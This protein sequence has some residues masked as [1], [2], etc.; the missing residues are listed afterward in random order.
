MKI[1]IVGLGSIGQRHARNLR[2]I[3][4][5]S[6]EL[7]AW[8]VRALT[9]VITPAMQADSSRNVEA[10]YN[11]RAFD[12]LSQALAEKPDA[13]FICNP[14]SLHVSVAQS[15]AEQNCHLFIE[16][17]V[18]HTLT[19]LRE[20]L[21]TVNARKLVTLVGYQFR[22]HP[23]LKVVSGLLAAQAIGRILTVRAT[24]GEYLPG[25]H[26]Y[27]DYRQTYAASAAL[28]GGV[29]LSQI[30]EFD[31][32]YSLFGLPRS[33]YSLGGHWSSLDLLDVEDT[34]STL[35]DFLVEDKSVAVHL[36]Q[37]YVQR[38]PCRQC[39]IVGEQGKIVA[40]F[41]TLRV[42]AP[43]VNLDFGDFSG[44]DRNQLYLNQT[45]HFLACLNGRELPIVDLR[46]GIQSLRMAL[47]AKESIQ[48]GQPVALATE[49]RS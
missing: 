2:T 32:L 41:A 29:I 25:W 23:C 49:F 27:E 35:M 38:L 18:S 16:K 5:D 46:A 15:C 26:A 14:T 37:D 8:R 7:L 44:F 40:D 9:R 36:Q 21:T 19:G 3:L 24:V 42:I 1:L 34:A 43:G 48:T 39:E 30:H 20:L 31:Y 28:G 11:I 45:K 6:V 13:A 17:P 22:F 47:A 33:V 12:D 4:G 10:E